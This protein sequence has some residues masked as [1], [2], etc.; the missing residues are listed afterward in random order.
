MPEEDKASRPTPPPRKEKKKRKT[1]HRDIHHDARGG[2]GSNIAANGKANWLVCQLCR[3][4]V[5]SRNNMS[6]DYGSWLSSEF[7]MR[8][9]SL[10]V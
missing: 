7:L 2:G 9:L 10:G 4:A 8:S 5:A 1:V 3:S 6:W